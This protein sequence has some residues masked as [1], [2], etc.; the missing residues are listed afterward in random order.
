M[1]WRAM[2]LEIMKIVLTAMRRQ[3]SILLDCCSS[4]RA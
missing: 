4:I 1:I 2:L 3:M